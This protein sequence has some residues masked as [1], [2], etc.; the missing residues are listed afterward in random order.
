MLFFSSP[1]DYEMLLRLDEHLPRKTVDANVL[2]RLPTS[3]VDESHV[4]DYC[5]ICMDPY[6]LGQQIKTLPCEHIF[7]V[8]CIET[9]LKE[10]SVQCPLDN[11]PLV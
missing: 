3:N 10:F 5:T 1:N 2:D 8:H 9:Y 6:T 7:H 11:L 4:N